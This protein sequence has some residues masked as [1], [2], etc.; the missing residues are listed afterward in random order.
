MCQAASCSRSRGGGVPGGFVL[1][2]AGGGCT[3]RLRT[4]ARG[5]VPPLRRRG[6]LRTEPPL[7][8]S[9]CA[10]VGCLLRGWGDTWD[11]APAP[12]ECLR[13]G[14]VH[15][16]MTNC[17]AQ[18]K[19]QCHTETMKILHTS[20]WHL[21]R[22]F[23]RSPLTREHQQFIDELL[24]YVHA[25]GIDTLLISGDVY[26]ST[27]PTAESTTLLDQALTRLMRAG[28]HVILSSGNH[29]SFRRLSYGAAFFEASGVH[30]CTT[31]ED[32][33]RPVELTDGTQR[34]HVYAIPY[35]A[36]RLHATALGVDPTHQAVLGAVTDAIRADA[37]ER[38]AR[39][40]GADRIIVMSHAT[41]S[42]TTGSADTTPRSD[43]ERDISVGGIDWVPASLF[44]GFDYVAL[45][46][47]HK[48]YPVTHTIRYSGS[49]LGFSFSEEHNR[50]GAYLIELNP[51]E[52]PTI[53]SHEWA[54]R[55]HMKT[56][57]GTMEQLLNDP[58]NS[59]YE[60]GYYC[61]I[62]LTDE[63]LPVGA[64]DRLRSRYETISHFSYRSTQ[65]AAEKPAAAPLTRDANPVDTFDQFHQYVR[66]R[67]LTSE[68]RDVI[69]TLNDHISSHKDNA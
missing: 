50:N 27:I 5:G 1:T 57:R 22:T 17:E 41:V 51:G 47:I 15:R 30:L 55:V 54:T 59:P 3:G 48:R 67:P 13:R 35:L 65:P 43:S 58:E 9:T 52:E 16:R 20:D 46:H 39:G 64:V 28:V 40:E 56:L 60:Q 36:P 19:T 14:G 23:H 45:G 18:N 62:E 37:A 6:A 32:A 34:V 29:D 49:P 38:R 33:T 44:D 61:R 66:N 2:L 11:G 53:S 24:D 42:D 25:E 68:E 21:G 4:H 8:M 63:T 31:I 69:T 10:A 12:R 26:D 7:R